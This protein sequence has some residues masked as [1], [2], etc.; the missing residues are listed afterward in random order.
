MTDI[1][2]QVESVLP[3]EK[4]FIDNRFPKIHG[5]PPIL[6]E[7][8]NYTQETL[9]YLTTTERATRLANIVSDKFGAEYVIDASAGIGGNTLGFGLNPKI[10]KVIS[11]EVNRTRWNILHNNINLYKLNRKV[12][13]YNQKFELNED[14]R[15]IDNNYRQNENKTVV[16]FDPPWLNL[17]DSIDKSN[18]ILNGIKLSD[19]SLEDWC[20]LLAQKGYLGVIM[21]LPK[22]YDLVLKGKIIDDDTDKKS[23]LI[24]Y[25]LNRDVSNRLIKDLKLVQNSQ[26][27]IPDISKINQSVYIPID[28]IPRPALVKGPKIILQTYLTP[29]FPEKPFS[30]ESHYNSKAIWIEPR[31]LLISEIEFL[32]RVIRKSNDSLEQESKQQYTLLYVG[33]APALHIPILSGMFPE[34]KFVLYDT[35]PFEIKPTKSIEIH[36]TLFDEKEMNKYK[37]NEKKENKLIFICHKHHPKSNTYHPNSEIETEIFN[38]MYWQKYLVDNLKPVRSLLKFRL[39]L[40]SSPV[41]KIFEYYDGIINLPAYSHPYSTE[42]RLEIGNKQ[43]MIQYNVE[44]YYKQMFA[45]NSWYRAQPFQHYNSRYGWSY[46]TIREFIIIQKYCQLK[47]LKDKFIIK[48]IEDF[49]GLSP[50]P[51]H[52]ISNILKDY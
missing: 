6:K 32:T 4:K 30:A 37:T 5:V 41:Y 13:A 51:E 31:K 49:D 52:K 33:A 26:P 28:V 22:N 39:P 12:S 15:L 48:F 7:N 29:D 19:L 50:L 2:L 34:I 36:Q 14:L 18:Y 10:K 9:S 23:R 25:T 40:S 38:Y 8:I 45:F 20:R 43:Q 17:H 21:H 35:V 1:S 11:Y 46:D 27:E 16:Y 42:T 44:S 24:Y 3:I 47:G